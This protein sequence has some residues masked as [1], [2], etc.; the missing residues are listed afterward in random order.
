M[1][2]GRCSPSS[3]P[4]RHFPSWLQGSPGLV[5]PELCPGWRRGCRRTPAIPRQLRCRSKFLPRSASVGIAPRAPGVT[6]Q[7]TAVVLE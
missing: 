4:H 1:G 3:I 2:K 7:K 5:L 6:A